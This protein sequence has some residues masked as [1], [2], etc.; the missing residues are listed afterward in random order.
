MRVRKYLTTVLV[1]AMLISM[2]SVA[3]YAGEFN[4]VK[5]HWAEE[6]INRWSEYS[7][8]EGYN[9]LFNP[10]EA[11]TR[12][13]LAVILDK[14][15]KYQDKAKNTFGDLS[16]TWYTDAILKAN[17]AGVIVGD[18]VNLRPND[19]VTR[20]EAVAM[21]G[22]AFGIEEIAG[23]P[24]FIDNND[25]SPWAVGYVNAF[26]E[27]G[28][29]E[30]YNNIFNPKGE[31]SRAA[32][33]TI[34][35]KII[36]GF[37]NK[38]GTYSG[39][40][41]GNVLINS[42]DVILKD[43]EIDGDL[44]IAP[45][46]GEGEVS[47]DN[48]NVT[49]NILVRGGGDHSILFNRVTVK[50][51]VIV[52]KVGNQVKIVV[53]GNSN[54]NLVVLEIGAIVAN[55]GNNTINILIPEDIAEGAR[56]VLSGN[57]GTV[58]NNSAN[59][60]I[61]ANGTI[62]KLELNK[63]TTITG[64]VSIKNI[65][66][67]VGA[68]STI[69]G[70][71]FEGGQTGKSYDYKSGS[72]GKGGSGGSG[73]GGSS[74]EDINTTPDAIS[75]EKE[76]T[77]Y[78]GEVTIPYRI[79]AGSD[80]TDMVKVLLSGKKP[81]NKIKVT[82]TEKSDPEYYITVTT[83]PNAI[84][85]NKQ[86]TTSD[87]IAFVTLNFTYEDL[88]S[89]KD[90]KITIKAPVWEE[91]EF[92]DPRF[93]AGYP[94]AEMDPDTKR[95]NLVVKLK[96]GVASEENPV[97]VFIVATDYNANQKT[98]VASVIHGHLGVNDV[99]DAYRYPYLVVNDNNEHIIET[100]IILTGRYDIAAYFVL[101]DK[102]TTSEQPTK[103]FFDG[104][105]V[106]YLDTY[107]PEQEVAYINDARDKIVVYFDE[108]LDINSVPDK[109]AFGIIG[110]DEATVEGV[111]ISNVEDRSIGIVTLNVSGIKP[112]DDITGLRIT[113]TPPEDNKLQDTADEPNPCE[114][115]PKEGYY[116]N[117]GIVEEA[118][119]NGIVEEAGVSL[120]RD[121]IHISD[122][123]KYIYIETTGAGYWYDEWHVFDISVEYG[124]QKLKYSV[125]SL[126]AT[127]GYD[128]TFYLKL[129]DGQDLVIDSGK[130]FTITLTPIAGG[131]DFAGDPLTPIT[132]DGLKPE[133]TPI[134]FKKAEYD[135]DGLKVFFDGEIGNFLDIPACSFTLKV[136]GKTH[137]LRGL[138]HFTKR[139]DGSYILFDEANIPVTINPGDE[140]LITYKPAHENLSIYELITELSGRPM[141]EFFDKPVENNLGTTEP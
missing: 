103:L 130:S 75:I 49:G 126:Y 124:A 26:A 20:Q 65:E 15:M 122:D 62:D 74:D 33:V 47:L 32:A 106:S 40:F 115:I 64:N 10:N 141:N 55:D 28:Y 53:T 5:G 136:N 42:S 120:E 37:Y 102:N 56:I 104:E 135:I 79:E 113:Y 80:I 17:A 24:D 38:P 35:D 58:Q 83:T 30:G 114:A 88:I 109:T 91:P 81:H 34:I 68:D 54:I 85:L 117:N 112:E 70:K 140:L 31:L 57:F 2:A 11:I 7:V 27:K 6:A 52:K 60:E 77:K 78:A 73:G 22:R 50:G 101:K 25:I 39:K 12:A 92:V 76:A 96:D 95:V 119:N 107:P 13:Q 82:I 1:I 29:I 19:T 118:Y 97:E 63:G 51:S 21:I 116:Y 93:A 43:T 16:D 84:M 121:N 105:T 69:N 90:V 137:I 46:V 133:E 48:V 94:Y 138:V 45:G 128:H 72:G 131:V 108:E 139:N 87:A 8:I 71:K 59:L 99:I 89:T 18:G 36:K 23:Q 44:I 98:D 125:Y 129:E 66:T 14:I 111:T 61:E 123:G 100:D 86:A 132:I 9:G 3:V 127:Y 67:A 4:D 134:N 41:D 110:V